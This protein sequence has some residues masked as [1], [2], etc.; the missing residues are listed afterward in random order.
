MLFTENV[1][2]ALAGLKA[3]IMRSL[4]TML[5]IIIGIASVIAIMTVG[6]SITL[7]VNSTMQGL[8]ANNLQVG[9]MQKSTDDKS[10]TGMNYG[11]GYVRDMTDEDLIT[12][13]MLKAFKAEYSDDIKYILISEQIGDYGT[14]S[15]V[16]HNGKDAK[17]KIVGYNRDYMEFNDKKVV[18]GR[19]FLNQDYLEGKPVCM[20]SDK[21]VERVYKGDNDAVLGKEIEVTMDG[22]TFY[23]FYVVGVYEYVTEEFS[24]GETD[25]PTTEVMVP[26]ERARKINHTSNKGFNFVMLVTSVD[27]DNNTFATTVRDYF[28]VNFYSRNDA[29]E[30]AVIS[31]ASMMNQMNSMIGMIQLALSV[32][33]GISLVVGGIGV[34]NIMLVSITERTKEIGTRKALGAT[35]SS[36]RLQFI[37]ESV[38]ICVIG[39]IIGIVL[40]VVLGTIAV[41]LMGYEAVVS[42]SSIFIAVGFSMAIGIFFGYYPANK[43]AKLNPIDALRYE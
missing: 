29:Y 16:S 12:K 14:S 1:L 11:R 10:D 36:I 35:N 9:V 27:T 34:M 32:I 39:G 3:N 4:L 38:V 25:N 42:V 15:K 31:M 23:S 18:A 17:T 40:G 20:V 24:F 5:G 7:I 13:D 37:T 2:V 26:L 21:L 33:A 28:N 43:A 30:I 41:K 6:N 19:S 8:G 22:G